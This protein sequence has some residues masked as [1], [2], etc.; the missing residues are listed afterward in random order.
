LSNYT[1]TYNNLATVLKMQENNAQM[2]LIMLKDLK[3]INQSKKD[4]G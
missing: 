1:N 3:K 2:L 4:F